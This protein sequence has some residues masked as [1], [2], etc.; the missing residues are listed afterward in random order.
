MVYALD[1]EENR[2]VVAHEFTGFPARCIGVHWGPYDLSLITRHEDG[3]VCEWSLETG[4]K[5]FEE[6]IHTG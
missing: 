5:K 1:E 4:E 2:F 6:Q 3:S